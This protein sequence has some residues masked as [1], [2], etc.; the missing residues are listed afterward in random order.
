MRP[1][2][3]GKLLVLGGVTPAPDDFRD[4]HAVIEYDPGQRS[5]KELPSMLQARFYYAVT[6]LG[7]GV[8]VMGGAHPDT[9]SV[10][11]HTRRSQCWGAMPSLPRPLVFPAAIA[12]RV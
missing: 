3:E 2:W 1:P 5:W 9:K 11:R 8:V 7:G 4:L 6:V 10:E 12:V